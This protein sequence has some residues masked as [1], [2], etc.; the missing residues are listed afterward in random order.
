MQRISTKM[1]LLSLAILGLGGI[2]LA[3][4]AAAQSC[5]STP[6]AWS[7]SNVGGN[8]TMTIGSP[9]MNS[10]NCK[11]E[12]TIGTLPN[13]RALVTDNSP[14]NEPRYRA[15]FYLD[16]SGAVSSLTV[17]NQQVL[18]F[19]SLADN[20][21]PT[22]NTSELYMTLLGSGSGP[23]VRMYVANGTSY[24]IVTVPLPSSSN[25]QYRIE[26]DLSQGTGSNNFRYWVTD[27]AATT[28]DTSPTGTE[29][30][31]NTGWSGVTMT[32]LGL[33]TTS[34]AFRTAVSGK[35]IA[36]D[37]FDSRRQTFIGK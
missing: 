22:V 19:S 8:G 24:K 28:N 2:A 35:T 34:A 11:L 17:P 7:S 14:S 13:T 33:F 20:G 36:F 25:N 29:S 18:I 10:T 3:G 4:S 9:G 30:V 37:E 12:L 27:A 15:R 1:K 32:N 6:D 23:A 5:P 21:P 26:I 16:L 31:D